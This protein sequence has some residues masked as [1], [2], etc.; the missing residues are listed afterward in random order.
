MET[1]D[2]ASESEIG[3]ELN[4]LRAAATRL[5]D[6]LTALSS[7]LTP[8]LKHHDSRPEPPNKEIETIASPI[9]DQ[10]RQARKSI[11]VMNDMVSVLL[12]ELAV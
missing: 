10:I 4:K 6:D 11:K 9:G 12:S 7:R 3:S 5:M 1:L 2:Q 8:V